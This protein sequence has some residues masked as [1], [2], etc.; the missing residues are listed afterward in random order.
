LAVFR[1]SCITSVSN[2]LQQ[3]QGQQFALNVIFV[4]TGTLHIPELH[5]GKG[6]G[7]VH[8]RTGHESPEGEKRYSSTVSLNL[9][10]DGRG[11]STKCPGHFT[12]GK[13]P[14]PIG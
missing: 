11:W 3:Q 10:L 8:P 14:V 4:E 5:T 12:T 2:S 6:K 9:A 13:D 7:K 1:S